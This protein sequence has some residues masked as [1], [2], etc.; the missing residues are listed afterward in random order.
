[1]ILL[2]NAKPVW[3]P[4]FSKGDFLG[5]ISVCHNGAT[6]TQ[7]PP[8]PPFRKGGRPLCNSVTHGRAELD[9]PKYIDIGQEILSQGLA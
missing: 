5:G 6:I 8:R 2:P 7:N 4:P 1:M 9:D 3:S